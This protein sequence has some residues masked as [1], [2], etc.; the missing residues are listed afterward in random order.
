VDEALSLAEAELEEDKAK[1][2]EEERPGECLRRFSSFTTFLPPPSL[3][4][5]PPSPSLPLP[6][7]PSPSLLHSSVPTHK[8]F[9]VMVIKPDAVQDGKVEEILERV[10]NEGMEVLATQEHL[11]TKEEAM[12]FYKQHEGS[13]SS[14]TRY[15]SLLIIFLQ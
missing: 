3:S 7:P 15:C 6:P 14:Q 5:S 13:V 1:E 8:Q 4:A 11:F 2:A 10:K 12:E 9:T